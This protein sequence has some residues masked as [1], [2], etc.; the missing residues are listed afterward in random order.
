MLGPIKQIAVTV[1]DL[2]ASK[3]F[4]RDK[5]G[6]KFLFDAP[7]GLSFF[8]CNG[9]WLMLG[10]E[11]AEEALAAPGSTLYFEVEDINKTFEEMKARGVEFVDQPHRIADMGSYEL[12]M[13]FFRDP[14]GTLLALRA[15]VKK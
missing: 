1:K 6:L 14:D 2:E 12:W 5:A 11:N 3:V 13:T 9:I 10:Q 8:D 4:Y 15:E 7:P